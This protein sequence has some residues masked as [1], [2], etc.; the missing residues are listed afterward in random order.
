MQRPLVSVIV[1]V[2]NEVAYIENM[3]KSV[4]AQNRGNFDMELL[5][6][7]GGS[8][9][10][11]REKISLLQQQNNTIRLINNER[12]ITPAA[13]NKGIE[14]ARGEYIS[15]LGA[16]SKYDP[17]YLQ[18]CLTEMQQNNCSG[19][20]GKVQVVKNDGSLEGVLVY[21]L[22]TSKFGVSSKSYRT[23]GEGISEHCPYPVFK[24][25]VFNEVG[26]Y[27]EELV[28][29][30]DNDMNYR[31]R[32]AGHNLYYTHK[33]SAYY[34][35]KQNLRGLFV[36]AILSGEW[37]A[38]SLRVNFRS[39]QLRHVIP[40]FFTFGIIVLGLASIIWMLVSRQLHNELN[41]LLNILVLLHFLLGS[42]TAFASLKES[43][44]AG[45]LALPFLFFAFH[46]LYGW[47]TLKELFTGKRKHY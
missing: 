36:Y 42:I 5:V 6:V 19:C 13:F 15:I 28:R 30:Q 22:L 34:F 7:D 29:N 38:V 41:M 43:K 40:L 39:M 21:H 3:L 26:L 11:T 10:G 14:H 46:F 44:R 25:V 16:H 18:V 20:S 2:L 31:I 45:I 27:N 37:N 4:L 35:P 8:T 33:V 17:D 1:P 32:K 9:D 47:G 12:K 24:Q 23:A